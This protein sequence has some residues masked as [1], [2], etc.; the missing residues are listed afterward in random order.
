M[1]RGGGGTLPLYVFNRCRAVGLARSMLSKSR[2]SSRYTP[3][4]LPV[5]RV[6]PGH[7]DSESRH[8]GTE[9]NANTRRSEGE[10]PTCEDDARAAQG[11]CALRLAPLGWPPPG[12]QPGTSHFHA[13]V[14]ENARLFRYIRQENDGCLYYSN[15]VMPKT[16][17]RKITVLTPKT[18]GF[19]L[20]WMMLSPSEGVVAMRMVARFS[21]VLILS[22]GKWCSICT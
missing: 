8:I 2:P 7:G 5:L 10:T 9:Q 21:L 18:G 22:A 4:P 12:G 13:G 1:R 6:N 16:V 20:C 19:A 11:E 14:R 15:V 17:G 3:P